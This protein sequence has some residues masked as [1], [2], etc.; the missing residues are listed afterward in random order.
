M[1]ATSSCSRCSYSR[2][3]IDGFRSPNLGIMKIAAVLSGCL[4]CLG[5]DASA[6]QIIEGE[7][8]PNDTEMSIFE[9]PELEGPSVL[10]ESSKLANPSDREIQE[11]PP[12]TQQATPSQEW[13]NTEGAI[14]TEETSL[15]PIVIE[16]PAI[17]EIPWTENPTSPRIESPSPEYNNQ[18]QPSPIFLGILGTMEDGWGFKIRAVMKGSAA[19]SMKLEPG[20]VI[21]LVNG[22]R[23]TSHQVIKQQLR[24][25]MLQ[26]SG[27]GMVFIDNVRGRATNNCKHSGAVQCGLRFQSIRFQLR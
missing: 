8:G 13:K 22:E 24:L 9:T 12:I 16:S 1:I 23:V 11:Q 17:D 25:S 4:L 19:E 18:S 21:V 27:K 2:C 15:P 5:V 10:D 6:T 7:P 14:L 26:N 3:S 20:D